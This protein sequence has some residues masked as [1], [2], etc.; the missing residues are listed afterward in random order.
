[1]Y[2][3]LLFALA[4]IALFATAATAANLPR[5]AVGSNWTYAE[6][7]NIIAN[8]DGDSAKI[9][10]TPTTKYTVAGVEDLVQASTGQVF[11]AYRITFDRT[12]INT[13]GSMSYSGLN[14]PIQIQ[15]ATY[16]GE[17][18]LE[19]NSYRMIR[20]RRLISG[21]LRYFTI[22]WWNAIG[23]INLDLIEEFVEPSDDF[24][25]PINNG[26]SWNQEMTLRALGNYSVTGSVLGNAIDLQ[27][28]LN[29]SI[30][31]NLTSSSSGPV[32]D[33][34]YSAMRVNQTLSTGG[35]QQW[36]YAASVSWYSAYFMREV[37]L[38]SFQI[39]SFRSLLNS[40]AVTPLPTYTPTPVP[41]NT[42][43]PTHTPTNTVPPTATFTPVPTNTPQPTDT[44][45]PTS[46]PTPT[47]FD[48]SYTFNAGWNGFSLLLQPDGDFRAADLAAEIA[49]GG[50][51]VNY[52]L[53]YD[54]RG[55][56]I[57]VPGSSMNN[58]PIVP[59]M[60]YLVYVTRS[61]SF[62]LDGA[63]LA[64]P[65]SYSVPSG[66]ALRSFPEPLGATAADMCN[67]LSTAGAEPLA[68]ARWKRR[69]W[70]ATDCVN[71]V[72]NFPLTPFDVFLVYTLNGY[73]N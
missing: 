23:P 39:R 20:R 6:D 66:W 35:T 38:D 45:Q 9:K 47:P 5:V 8:F 31:M 1:M 70:E 17:V 21:T 65:V 68:L 14:A 49:N 27:G 48:G 2:R 28:D 13:S 32:S 42:P 72:Y 43:V 22:A 71:L 4:A 55:W 69:N 62:T 33:R 11:R 10:L 7:L 29:S 59:T 3:S 60:G 19:E 57:H 53:A 61:G 46:T 26:E 41:T 40:S 16:S 12:A 58:F 51:T 24:Q 36:Y 44:P 50:M 34:T 52:I 67:E 15:N 73:E 54:R 18:W 56:K 64:S 63:P 25:F 37:P 30:P